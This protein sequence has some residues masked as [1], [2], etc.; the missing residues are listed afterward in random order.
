MATGELNKALFG[1]RRVVGAFPHWVE[2]AGD[3]SEASRLA[4]E[5]RQ[6]AKRE[7]APPGEPRRAAEPPGL[8]S[9]AE[10]PPRAGTAT[11]SKAGE[12]LTHVPN[13]HTPNPYKTGDGGMTT[14]SRVGVPGDE[15]PPPPKVP[16][17]PNLTPDE[18]QVESRFADLYESSPDAVVDNYLDRLKKG[19]VG[20]APN[21]FATDDVKLLS[22]DY[23]PKGKSEDEVK[24]ARARYNVSVHQTA[25]AV[26]KKAFLKYLDDTVSSLPPEKRT[27][28]VTSG[29]VAAGKGYAI[30]SVSEASE[31]AKKVGAIYDS[32]GEQNGTENKWILEECEK[33]GIKTT[34]AYVHANPQE[35]WEN[36]KRGVLER[37]GRTGRVVDAQLFAESYAVGAKNFHAF[38]EQHQG[39]ADFFI[40]DNSGKTPKRLDRIPEESLK[41]NVD[42]IHKRALKA[43][44]ER[45]EI[46]PAV[47]RGATIG[48]RIW[49]G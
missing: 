48:R 13:P 27:V 25:N 24:D 2:K 5:S 43:I 26:A 46:K 28:L 11:H 4:W 35:T 30:S 40:L 42:E 10:A 8:S 33:R 12:P 22:P 14:S 15:V 38:M 18:R 32:A 3:R 20:D 7:Q 29:G 37:A 45:P 1:N 41:W 34:F 44:D 23:N 49:E 9:R 6:R 19:E 16:R 47:R 39:D 17:L 31:V 36:P 21:V